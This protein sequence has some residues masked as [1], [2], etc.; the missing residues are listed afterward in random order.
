MNTT[1]LKYRTNEYFNEKDT[2][3]FVNGSGSSLFESKVT[4]NKGYWWTVESLNYKCT[5]VRCVKLRGNKL[6][7]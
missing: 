1:D 4:Y 2:Y 6:C 7:Q 5:S 3:V